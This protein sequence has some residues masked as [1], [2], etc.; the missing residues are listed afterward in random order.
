MRIFTKMG[1]R[2]MTIEHKAALELARDVSLANDGK[3]GDPLKTPYQWNA[4]LRL[5]RAYLSL[6]ERLTADL[7]ARHILAM[8]YGDKSDDYEIDMDCEDDARALKCAR[9]ILRKIGIGD[10]E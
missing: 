10:G 6:R 9:A 1:A 2:E 8:Q 4:A 3:H 5:A 7:I